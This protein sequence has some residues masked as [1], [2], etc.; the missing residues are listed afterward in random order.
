M[1]ISFFIVLLGIATGFLGAG[2]RGLI[3]IPT[4]IYLGL[5]PQAAIATNKLGAVGSFSGGKV[6]VN[7]QHLPS[8]GIIS[9]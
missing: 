7:S 8:G 6:L 2:G 1:L 3:S 4:L 5:T 9:Q